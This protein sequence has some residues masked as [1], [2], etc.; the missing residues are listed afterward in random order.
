MSR[1]TKRNV[2]LVYSGLFSIGYFPDFVPI[3]LAEILD[4]VLDICNLNQSISSVAIVI[5]YL[6]LCASLT[7]PKGSQVFRVF[8]SLVL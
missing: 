6:P 2:L 8:K 4:I 5:Y 7:K 1:I 3:F